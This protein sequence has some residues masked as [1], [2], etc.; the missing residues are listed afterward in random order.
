[1]STQED[2]ERQLAARAEESARKDQEIKQMKEQM[3]LLKESMR[4]QQDIMGQLQVRLNQEASGRG[5]RTSAVT[6]VAAAGAQLEVEKEERREEAKT[7]EILKLAVPV[8]EWQGKNFESWMAKVKLVL[9]S[10]IW[11]DIG[12][13]LEG[14]GTEEVTTVVKTE[15]K[16][17]VSSTGVKLPEGVTEARANTFFM[18]LTTVL[19]TQ[20]LPMQK[21]ASK[22][23]C[24]WTRLVAL[25]G[26]VIGKF[27]VNSLIGRAAA[28]QQW[29]ELKQGIEESFSSFVSRVDAIER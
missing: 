6:T 14:V 19:G 18:W 27:K 24:G 20:F 22:K 28:Q 4:K 8:L 26:G 23:P 17:V 13:A 29:S 5:G 12:T 21:R 15:G 9:M 2:L 1:M 11:K 10:R 16:T 25:W 3:E 7:V